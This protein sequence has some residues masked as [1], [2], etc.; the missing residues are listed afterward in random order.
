MHSFGQPAGN[1]LRDLF[2]DADAQGEDVARGGQEA[3]RG[4]P[5]SATAVAMG[6][7]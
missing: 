2:I 6:G 7:P 3:C 1:E 4:W 5:A